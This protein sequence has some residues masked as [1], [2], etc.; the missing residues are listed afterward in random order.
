MAVF[1]PSIASGIARISLSF[2]ALAGFAVVVYLASQGFDRAV[3]L[4]PTWFLLVSW[5]AAAGLAVR[6]G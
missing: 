2:V 6:T 5:V 1:E 3:L 4:V